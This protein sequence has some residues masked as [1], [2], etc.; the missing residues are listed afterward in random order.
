MD[1]KRLKRFLNIL[2]PVGAAFLCLLA[3][4][5]EEKEQL[6]PVVEPSLSELVVKEEEPVYTGLLYTS[7]LSAQEAAVLQLPQPVYQLSGLE[8]FFFSGNDSLQ[9]YLGKCIAIKG[10]IAPGWEQ[11]PVQVNNQFTYGRAALQVERIMLQE[12]DAC[13]AMPLTASAEQP[14]E[15]KSYRG[16]LRRMKRPAPDIAY[17]YILLLDKPI[18]DEQHAIQPGRLVHELP[19]SISRAEQLQKI[20]KLLRERK[21]VK[22]EA[23]LVSGYAER[24]VLQLEEIQTGN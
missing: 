15:V 6:P 13:S 4:S 7:G 11:Q 19:I 10:E 8:S 14:G 17:D 22:L 3:C 2:A 1:F 9:A 24:R 21:P 20:E 16:E 5:S 18:A 23:S 12:A